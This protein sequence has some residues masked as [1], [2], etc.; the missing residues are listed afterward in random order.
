MPFAAVAAKALHCAMPKGSPVE[1]VRTDTALLP[2]LC[3]GFLACVL[4]GCHGEHKESTSLN[5]RLRQEAYVWQRVWTAPVAQAIADHSADFKSLI[6]LGAEVSWKAGRVD[7]KRTAIDFAALRSGKGS[8]GIALRIGP[9]L[10]PFSE[11]DAVTAMLGELASSLVGACVSNQVT[12]SELQIDFDCAS[13]KLDGY[14]RWI[15]AIRSRLPGLPVVITALPSWLAEP[16]FGRLIAATDGFVL[17]VHSLDRP[18][19][20][21]APFTLCDPKAAQRAVQRAAR[22]GKP[23]RVALPTYGYVVAFDRQKKFIGLSAEGPKRVWPAGAVTRE[24]RA[25]PEALAALVREW[26]RS[27][28]PALEGLIWYRLP[29]GGDS[30]NWSWPTLAAVM[31]G[32]IPRERVR[33]EGVRPHSGLIELSLENDG[34]RSSGSLPAI[35]VQ[36]QHAHLVAGDGLGGYWLETRRGDAAYLTSRDSPELKPGERRK[37]GWLRLDQGE[38]PFAI[39]TF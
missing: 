30:L 27:R 39:R 35:E 1:F 26:S 22:F 33:A 21:D 36:W 25:E 34:E 11:G 29:I 16:G 9:Y 14:R 12:V 10:G 8:A 31:E 37:I 15:E 6:V 17:Q 5:R 2:A 38:A 19:S 23:F 20:A 4:C 18:K 24:T 7:V 32:R 3:L 13:S 28:P